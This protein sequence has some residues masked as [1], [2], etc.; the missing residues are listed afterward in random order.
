MNFTFIIQSIKI[1]LSCYFCFF[2]KTCILNMMMM[3]LCVKCEQLSF[4]HVKLTHKINRLELKSSNESSVRW[5][6]GAKQKSQPPKVLR[7]RNAVQL[8][9][10]HSEVQSF[11]PAPP[12]CT[13][14]KLIRVSECNVR[15][16][17][18]PESKETLWV[19]CV[20][21][22]TDIRLH[23]SQ[24]LFSSLIDPLWSQHF[25]LWCLG[26]DERRR[27]SE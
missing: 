4:S 27:D 6:E 2:P 21:Y 12:V 9:M 10:C 26:M 20:R 18:S 13:R 14:A 17:L 7:S 19:I 22:N 11:T 1:K 23:K 24:V 8:L 25:Q 5:K 15:N 3:F 16:S